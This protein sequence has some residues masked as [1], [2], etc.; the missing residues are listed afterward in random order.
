[1]RRSKNLFVLVILCFT[2]AGNRV[3][4]AKDI[5]VKAGDKEFII[6]VDDHTKEFKGI[7]EKDGKVLGTRQGAVWELEI[8]GGGMDF[9]KIR[10]ITDGTVI[11]SGD[12]TCVTY[13]SNGQWYQY[14]W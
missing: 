5:P 12:G 10:Y 7:K 2:F 14:C 9:Q 13:F 8:G 4:W 6:Q 3:L 11:I 1:M